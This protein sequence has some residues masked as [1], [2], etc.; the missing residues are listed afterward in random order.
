[1]NRMCDIEANA[2]REFILDPDQTI[3]AL[4]VRNS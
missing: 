1:M 2:V 4:T 3:S